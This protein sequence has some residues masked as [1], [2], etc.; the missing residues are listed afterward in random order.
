MST[1]R[2]FFFGANTAIIEEAIAEALKDAD[3][4]RKGLIRATYLSTGLLSDIRERFGVLLD[5]KVSR[6]WTT[7]VFR[8]HVQEA[9]QAYLMFSSTKAGIQKIVAATT[10][11]PPVLR[12]IRLLDNWIL[13]KQWLP[14]RFFAETDAFIVSENDG[15]YL[16]PEGSN[17]LYITI[18]G[19]VTQIAKL[20]TGLSVTSQEI[21]DALNNTLVG[22]RAYPYGSRRF[23]IRS[24]EYTT[25]GSIKIEKNSSAAS[26][27][28]FDLFE[29]R[30][31]PAPAGISGTMPFGWRIEGD[32]GIVSD[33]R[34]YDGA[35]FGVG[36]AVLY[37]QKGGP[38]SGL[39]TQS[40]LKNGGFEDAFVEWD[41]SE[42]PDFFIT[43]SLPHSGNRSA[44]VITRRDSSGIPIRNIIKSAR[45][46]M[47]PAGTSLHV[48]GFYK[49]KGSS[50]IMTGGTPGTTYRWTVSN[51]V[52][53]FI[54]GQD[55][56][57]I[58][59][60]E[61]PTIVVHDTS[62]DFITAG[63]VP[64]M[65][66]ETFSNNRP[67]IGVIS[68]VNT[69][70]LFID[71][72]RNGP[73]FDFD[74]PF[75]LGPYASVI[76]TLSAPF[77]FSGPGIETLIVSV[78]NGPDQV[79][80][81]PDDVFADPANATIDEVLVVLSGLTGQAPLV[82]ATASDE[83]G[84]L[85]LTSNTQGSA[86]GI[87]IGVA[88]TPSANPVLGFLDNQLGVLSTTTA[89]SLTD[90]TRDFGALGVQVGSNYSTR[91]KIRVD[92][93][94][95]ALGSIT[96]QGQAVRDI[97]SIPAPDT[98][99]VLSWGGLPIP[100]NA[101]KYYVYTRPQDGAPYQIYR[102]LSESA[103]YAANAIAS[104]TFKFSLRFLDKKGRIVSQDFAGNDPLDIYTAVPE[105]GDFYLPLH[106][107]AV[108]PNNAEYGQLI[109]AIEPDNVGVG[110]VAQV[111]DFEW[112]SEDDLPA[113]LHVAVDGEVKK[114]P[115][116]S[117]NPA[118]ILSYANGFIS[119]NFQP[120]DGPDTIL[121]GNE[122]YEFDLGGLYDHDTG[123]ITYT[124]LPNHGDTITIDTITV[125]FS[126]AN[127]PIIPPPG[128]VVLAIQ[129]TVDE[130][131]RS[132]CDTV[133]TLT[134]AV[135]RATFYEDRNY[136]QLVATRIYVAAPPMVPIPFTMSGANFAI[137]GAGTLT[138]PTG[139]SVAPGNV[140]VQIGETVDQT[141][142]SLE[143][144]INTYSSSVRADR[145]P[146]TRVIEITSLVRGAAGSAISFVV[147]SPI[148]AV[149]AD[150]T[151][152]HLELGES[153]K[154]QGYFIYTVTPSDGEQVIMGSQVY[155]FDDNG[156]V[157]PT[158][159]PVPLIV[160]EVPLTAAECYDSLALL[161]NGVGGVSVV[162]D[163]SLSR[164][165]VTALASGTIGNQLTLRKKSLVGTSFFPTTGDNGPQYVVA[166]NSASEV[167]YAGM[168]TFVLD[169]GNPAPPVLVD[170]NSSTAAP[171]TLT[172][173][174][175][176][177]IPAGSSVFVCVTTRAVV[178][179]PTVTDTQGNVY[180]LELSHTDKLF[181]YKSL[182]AVA[183]SPSDTITVDAAPNPFTGIVVSSFYV[184]GACD[185]VDVTD[186]SDGSGNVLTLGPTAALAET[187]E[188]ALAIFSV[189]GDNSDIFTPP[190]HYDFIGEFAT[191]NAANELGLY[192]TYRYLE[193][194]HL[195]GGSPIFFQNPESLSASEV[196]AYI[197]FFP[198][199]AGKFYASNDATVEFPEGRIVLTSENSGLNSV[200]AIGSGSAA[201]IL[202][203]RNNFGVFQDPD[204]IRPAWR[205]TQGAALGDIIIESE[206]R[207]NAK[208][209]YGT[210]WTFRFWAQSSAVAAV[211]QAAVIF[212]N[213]TPNYGAPV[214]LNSEPKV[215][216]L[217]YSDTAPF[218]KI[219]V[220]IILSNALLNDTIDI[221]DPILVDETSKCLHLAD[222]TIIRN[223]QRSNRMH[224]MA[225]AG[226]LET[227]E[228]GLVGLTSFV[229]N[230]LVLL[231]DNNFVDLA[232]ENLFPRSERV[233][234]IGLAA[235][236]TISYFGQPTDGEIITLDTITFEFDDNV[237]VGPGN[238]AVTIGP[239][240]DDSY[241]NLA[242]IIEAT[243]PMVTASHDEALN[244][245][246]IT[247]RDVGVAGNGIFFGTT[248]TNAHL[249][250]LVGFLA[251]GVDPVAYA[252][253][254]DY[255]IRPESGELARTPVSAIPVPT[256]PDFAIDYFYYPSGVALNE[257]Y[258][259][260][261]KQIGE[262][263]EASNS[264]IF[265]FHGT[266]QDFL[267]GT[268]VNFEVVVRD[269]DEF[270]YLA[271]GT[272]GK[273]SQFL[274]VIAGLGT[275]DYQANITKTAILLKDGI[276]VPRTGG[277]DGDGNP[278]P[279]WDFMDEFTVIVDPDV[280]LPGGHFEIEYR[281][282]F[283]YTTPILT[284]G[285]ELTAFNLLPYSYQNYKIEEEKADV[286]VVLALDELL[287]AKLTLPAIEDQALAE[288]SRTFGGRTVVLSDSDWAFQDSLTVVLNTNAFVD[289]AIYTL[290]YKSSEVS[291]VSPITEEW[292]V[293]TSDD[294]FAFTGWAP[295]NV[296]DVR[297][298]DF[299]AQFR[300]TVSGDFL[301]HEYRLRSI[302]GIG[303]VN[304]VSYSG[305]GLT[306]FGTYS[307][308]D[309]I[310]CVVEE[311]VTP[312]TPDPAETQSVG[313]TL[314]LSGG[315]QSLEETKKVGGNLAISGQLAA[316]IDLPLAVFET[317]YN[318][319]A[320]GTLLDFSLAN[321]T[322]APIAHARTG[323]STS[324]LARTQVML[325]AG[326]TFESIWFKLL[327]PLPAGATATVR[328]NINGVVSNDIVVSFAPGDQIKG[329]TGSKHVNSFGL[330]SVQL[331][332]TG[333]APIG[334]AMT[335]G[336]RVDGIILLP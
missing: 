107:H 122:T 186:L 9:I 319:Y 165:T 331:D 182:T 195:I 64:G 149:M 31:A 59:I 290:N 315:S 146:G 15:P 27:V 258:T 24:L 85:K 284:I 6:S 196:V 135:V 300:V 218:S 335:I 86:S 118:N 67:Y 161:S 267:D 227:T 253:D 114:I 103:S 261:I 66:F 334:I 221:S 50:L 295:F 170:I 102:S 96:S 156:V 200:I 22:A 257:S 229:E 147:T 49:A 235:V 136:I 150:P 53:G 301:E 264:C 248:I 208:D 289:T 93:N 110:A 282:K 95:I 270:S 287:M 70:D 288:M 173:T 164:V 139:S 302:S 77:D 100:P 281:V 71:G 39:I 242:A 303:Q 94:L 115:F 41:T 155:E 327:A 117:G 202:G 79:F 233:K 82:G 89:T 250:P 178:G 5:T 125:H 213:G 151:S 320:P 222:N 126:S 247:A 25:E 271:P 245:C 256:P 43:S 169:N 131:W 87:R 13:G 42:G 304:A 230:E 58:D 260:H 26:I 219:K 276:P 177:G 184:T 216:E 223:K 35:V 88:P 181:I 252:R 268:R 21:I 28:G 192:P 78:D 209:V 316:N 306:P 54:Q 269:P 187:G 265:F 188:L 148:N 212:D 299:Y 104:A 190:D 29:R 166:T 57:E 321:T 236:G 4:Q 273:H 333:S 167:W 113:E 62:V 119:F 239:T 160:N 47:P 201:E 92:E 46:V 325:P 323:G 108:V 322:Y 44:A 142:D 52:Q 231:T 55:G 34:S 305:F 263:I 283:E 2:D 129:G 294:G 138:L 109:I 116:L 336:Y 65:S 215:V 312:P 241:A 232:Q 198:G 314:V 132:Y 237:A 158:A 120:D 124:G 81:F 76:S 144:T 275:L 279:G 48:E 133:N 310:D 243:S 23:I 18:N 266:E 180:V 154:A 309:P 17:L 220:R 249:T 11:I 174:P 297:D 105:A 296:G 36:P 207:P 179:V 14:N 234:R 153:D 193:S 210:T 307:F 162:H 99:E 328:L 91:D 308:G 19:Q 199:V 130:F 278:I 134:N 246:T 72:W 128:D 121:I 318:E 40:F 111:D 225:V 159:L 69:H 197:N 206:A 63:I 293:R 274:S 20:P 285:D 185:P 272:P 332:C 30:V 175:Q 16:I 240:M 291:Y 226:E 97:L 330:V 277:I 286:E 298:L 101:S 7:E 214:V 152:G 176:V 75:L 204:D 254:V 74:N 191:G 194:G 3:D 143:S 251:G 292:E 324:V 112:R 56:H 38:F 51:A 68:A 317:T 141:V 183:L 224:R 280:W 37:G 244:T 60:F 80:T 171:T 189:Q 106:F 205:V 163:A 172:I 259:Q 10:Q 32:P 61:A 123:F 238:V 168:A 45:R 73:G 262:K 127:V 137:S 1:F 12:P 311:S 33:P 145:L 329:A 98:L 90:S 83:M 228:V 84:S 140:P 326:V 203:F 157:N 255:T 8:E 313:G 217:V 211:A